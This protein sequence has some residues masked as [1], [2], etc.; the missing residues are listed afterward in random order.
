[1]PTGSVYP[2]EAQKSRL[3]TLFFER[4]AFFPEIEKYPGLESIDGFTIKG[5]APRYIHLSHSL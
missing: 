2:W 5:K 4:N 3:R 1:M